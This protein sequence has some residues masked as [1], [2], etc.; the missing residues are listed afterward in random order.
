V[1]TGAA[2]GIGR[3]VTE[4]FRAEGAQVAALDR[5]PIDGEPAAELSLVCDVS[6][7]VSVTESFEQIVAE[8]G[9]VDALV[10]SAGVA[11]ESEFSETKLADWNDVLAV[12]LTGSFLCAKHAVR[13]RSDSC[14]LVFISS[15]SALVATADEAAYC[16][17][18][19]GVIGLA[20]SIAVDCAP[21]GV[22]SNCICPGVIDT[23]LNEPM[24]EVRGAEFRRFVEQSH[25]LGQMAL[26]LASDE[27]TF[28]TGSSFVA[29]G[30]YTSR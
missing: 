14:S 4:R 22:R 13:R 29:D 26:F 27:S 18:K 16:A 10:T 2:S 3:A 30:G 15:M 5:V 12:N 8:L 9:P 20:R 25:P 23:P 11:L 19:A 28:V 6:D 24:W 17:S 21:L 7:E 1:V